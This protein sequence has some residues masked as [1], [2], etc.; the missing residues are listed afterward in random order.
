MKIFTHKKSYR[1]WGKWLLNCR[2]IVSYLKR[3][4]V[5]GLEYFLFS[6]ILGIS[7][8]QWTFIFVRGVQ[9]TNQKTT[10]SAY[11]HHHGHHLHQ[12][13]RLNRCWAPRFWW[14]ACSWPR[15]APKFFAL[16][17]IKPMWN[18]MKHGDLS[19]KHDDLSWFMYETCWFNLIYLWNMLI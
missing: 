3:I 17:G 12:V 4:L 8:S 5:G 14:P 11:E 13:A 16:H 1:H 9:T 10:P 7:S 15:S 19:I 18:T 2:L 6:H